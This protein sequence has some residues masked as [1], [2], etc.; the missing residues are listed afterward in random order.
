M[1]P[2]SQ[3]EEEFTGSTAFPISGLDSRASGDATKPGK[4]FPQTGIHR[5]AHRFLSKC[6]SIR[7]P[8]GRS[9]PDCN[10]SCQ[11]SLFKALSFENSLEKFRNC[12]ITYISSSVETSIAVNRILSCRIAVQIK[13]IVAKKLLHLQFIEK[14]CKELEL[15]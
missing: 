6:Q 13:D 12:I 7:I 11:Y 1:K 15:W 8:A 2:S 5:A 14:K 10:C 3:P 4:R 9:Q